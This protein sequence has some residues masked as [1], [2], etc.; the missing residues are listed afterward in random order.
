MPLRCSAVRGSNRAR[1]PGALQ[2][3]AVRAAQRGYALRCAL[4]LHAHKWRGAAR[5]LPVRV[6]E[7]GSPLLQGLRGLPLLFVRLGWPAT[8]RGQRRL[9]GRRRS[10][11]ARDDVDRRQVL[12]A[13]GDSGSALP[14]RRIEYLIGPYVCV[15]R[16]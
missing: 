11:R 8:L 16:P 1:E 12:L 5:D 15:L 10:L 3:L 7:R 2:L 6:A 14:E 9:P 13:V 4:G